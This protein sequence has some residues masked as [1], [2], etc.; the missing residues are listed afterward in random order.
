MS[1]YIIALP[2][3]QALTVGW[4]RPL[5]TFFALVER[6]YELISVDERNAIYEA[7]EADESRDSYC[8]AVEEAEEAKNEDRIT[9][10]LGAEKN[11]FPE[12]GRFIRRLTAEGF[13]ISDETREKLIKDQKENP[14]TK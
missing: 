12:I 7:T 10:W 8:T 6:P 14:F 2:T 5:N 11:E 13:Q 1:S 9:L 3:G 4:D